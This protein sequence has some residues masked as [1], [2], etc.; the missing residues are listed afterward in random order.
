M[1]STVNSDFI[2]INDIQEQ[3]SLYKDKKK[4]EPHFF[5]APGLI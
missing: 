2:L 1:E 5:E 4:K 3:F